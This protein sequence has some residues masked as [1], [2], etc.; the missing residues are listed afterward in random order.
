MKELLISKKD[1]RIAKTQEILKKEEGILPIIIHQ[2][3]FIHFVRIDLNNK[4]RAYYI[5]KVLT[6][7]L[8]IAYDLS[9]IFEKH[10]WKKGKILNRMFRVRDYDAEI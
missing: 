3:T 4:N 8:P 6:Q 5:K 1:L 2:L 7:D 10:S 9:S